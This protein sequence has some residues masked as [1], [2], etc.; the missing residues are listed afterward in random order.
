LGKA[1]LNDPN[2][3]AQAVCVAGLFALTIF[4]WAFRGLIVGF[5]SFA[6][7]HPAEN[8]AV[9]GQGWL[10][11]HKLYYFLLTMLILALTASLLAVRRSAM[12]A[13]VRLAPAPVAGIVVLIVIHVL[14]VSVPW[15]ILSNS[16]FEQATYAGNPCF[17]I[18]AQGTDLLVQCPTVAPPR[19]S[20]VRQD[21]PRLVRTGNL[22]FIF[23][24]YAA[25]ASR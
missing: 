12:R 21:D 10:N 1:E 13:K 8:L 9:L 16:K 7:E 24:G 23:N 18:G 15:R 6:N 20:V 5:T 17:I 4:G 11:T 3:A 25:P 22:S 2:S 14:L 19:N